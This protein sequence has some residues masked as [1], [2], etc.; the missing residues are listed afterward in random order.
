MLQVSKHCVVNN[1]PA[2]Q[3]HLLTCLLLIIT[4]IVGVYWATVLVYHATDS[5]PKLSPLTFVAVFLAMDGK[6]VCHVWS[7]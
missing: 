4:D 5:P 1:D 7:V 2:T 6:Y 3:I